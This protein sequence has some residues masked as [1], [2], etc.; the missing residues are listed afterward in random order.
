MCDP[1]AIAGFAISAASSVA[2]YMGQVQQAEQ[3][4]QL[5]RENAQRANE[6]AKQQYY[7]TQQ[8]MFQEQA[9]AAADKADVARDGRDARATAV[10]AAGESGVS[11]LSVDGLLAEFYGR[12]A[13]YND[14][15]DQ[16]TEWTMDQYNREMRG[17]KANAE[18]RIASVQRAAKP[19]F[20]DA[21]LRI[22]G[23]GLDA[24]SGYKDRQSQKS[25]GGYP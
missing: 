3:Q 24:Y 20:F 8:R 12:E 16:Q 10:V 2:G 21:G 17:V 5:Y 25:T 6:N 19:T 23:G 9:A 14:R 15:I 11:G 18:D 22:L 4:N 13:T 7:D 1:I